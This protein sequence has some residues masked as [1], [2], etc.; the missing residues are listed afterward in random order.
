MSYLQ[1][2]EA[3]AELDRFDEPLAA[4]PSDP[5]TTLSLLDEV[6]SDATVATTG[7]RNCGFVNGGRL[8]IALASGWL[9]MAWRHN[10]ALPVM[11]PVPARLHVDGAFGMWALADPTRQH[12]VD[13]LTEAE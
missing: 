10:A 13:G 11:S 8:P 4:Q 7:P 2:R 1:R 9:G 5:L 6:G 12:L 3:L